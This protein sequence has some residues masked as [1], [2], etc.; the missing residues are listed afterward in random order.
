ERLAAVLNWIITEFGGDSITSPFTPYTAKEVG[1][2]R[3]HPLNEVV[4]Y[5]KQLLRALGDTDANE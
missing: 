4:D 1:R 3:Q 2:L 5:R